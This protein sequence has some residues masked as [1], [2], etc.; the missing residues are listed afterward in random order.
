[1]AT[2]SIPNR[3]NEIR[4][5]GRS[6]YGEIVES[7]NLDLNR[8]FGKVFTSKKLLKVL[9]ATDNLSNSDA[10]AFA[11][12]AGDYYAS[13]DDD[14]Y[15]CAGTVDPTV[16]GN[17]SDET[18]VT[19]TLTNGTDLVVFAD[20]LL[21]SAGSAIFS[22]NGSTFS[23]SWSTGK[24]SSLTNATQMHV[25]RGGAE[26]LFVLD[27][28]TV[29]YWNTAAGAS[30]VTLQTDLTANCVTS[31]VNAIWVGTKSTSDQNAYVYEIYIGETDPV[32]A[33]PI[34]RN[35]YKVD[36]TAVM[37]IEVIDNV[38]Y[39]VTEKGGIQAF[40]GAGFSTVASF[41]FANTTE[42]INTNSIHPNGMKLHGDSLYINIATEIRESNE[43]YAKNTPSGIWEYNRITGQLTHRFAFAED[44]TENGAPHLNNFIGGALYIMDNTYGLLL[45]S[46]ENGKSNA[47]S[48]VYAD[49][50]SGFGYLITGELN[51][52]SVQDF[53]ES[54]YLKAKT[55]ASGESIELKYR[56]TKIDRE[57]ADCTASDTN[58]LN[59]TDTQ[60]NVA[61]GWEVTDI[62]TGKIA[63]ITKIK[64]TST[65][66]VY[67]LD[68]D[69]ATT[70]D[71]LRV[72]FNNF[73]PV[74]YDDR[75]GTYDG[76]IQQYLTADGELK[77]HGGFGTNPW[78]QFKLVMDG[79]IELRQ[80]LVKSNNKNGV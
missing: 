74:G 72:K 50:G 5:I 9:D 22:W 34:A 70:G 28:N 24:I 53:Y 60:T 27:E 44:D 13:T 20:L 57:F 31:G 35:A 54:V 10:N 11:F 46:A 59:T 6:D 38:P 12:Y 23:N 41:P 67:T 66:T 29:R 47:A 43:D 61:V 42:V 80:F 18:A 36:G 49:T 39:I 63:H 33:N 2:F 51:S 69:I 56:K 25:H 1:M 37:A 17:W 14:L 78:I 32:S 65:V 75:G 73:F 40:N 62:H 55:L 64:S 68:R 16:T 15:T 77:E 79:D 26:T 19:T 30:T 45:A 21:M 3:N 8:K 7:F 76:T 4:Q 58:V 48:G 52:D 71:A